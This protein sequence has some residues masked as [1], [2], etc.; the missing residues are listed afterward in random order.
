MSAGLGGVIKLQGEDAYRQA[1]KKISS[2]L[3]D[4]NAQMK[5][6]NST[7]DKNDKSISGLS[8]KND[9]LTKKL[10]AQND[11]LSEA[12]KMLSQAETAYSDAGDE[13]KAMQKA[14]EDAQKELDQA[15]SSTGA[16]AGEISKLEE[17]VASAKENLD[18]ANQTYD[19]AKNTVS[20]WSAEVNKAQADVNNTSNAITK[21]AEEMAKAQKEAKDSKSAYRELT[22]T[23]DSQ[24]RQLNTLKQQY[25]NVVLEQGK[26][27]KEA[28]SLKSEIKDLN[29]EIQ[30]N[31]AKLEAAKKG[32]EEYNGSL[33]DSGDAAQ[34]AQDGFTVMKGALAD[35]ISNGIQKATD[36]LKDL[37]KQTFDAGANFETAMSN[38]GAISGATGDDLDALTEKAKE[39]GSKTKFSATESA[40][41]FSYMAMAGWKTQDMIDGIDGVMNLAAASGADLAE[42]SDIVTDALT[43]MGYSAK[44][45]GELADVMAAAASNSNTNVEL[46]GQT[47]QYAAPIVGALG[48]NMEDTATAIGLMA[49]S[50]IKGEKAGTA[51]RSILTRLS[52]PTKDTQDAMDALGLSLTDSEGNMKDLNTV[53]GD[54]RNAFSGLSETQQT[55]YAKSIAGQEAMSGLLAIVNASPEDYDKLSDAIENSSGSAQEMADTMNDNVSGSLTLLK[56]QIEGEMIT[57]FESSSDTIKQAI[58]DIGDALASIDWEAVADAVSNGISKAVEVFQWILDNKDLIVSAL[59][60]IVAGFVAFKTAAAVTQLIT[61]FKSFFD[62]I[63][64]GQGVMAALNTVMSANPIA[65]IVAAVAALVTAFITAYNTSE[66]FRDTVNG[67]VQAV[68]DF[69]GDAIDVIKEILQGLGDFFSNLGQDISDIWDSITGFFSD[70]GD[71]IGNIVSG[72]GDKVSEVWNGIKEKTSEAWNNVK[73]SISTTVGNI[74]DNVSEGW[75]NIKEAT[76]NAWSNIKS[77]VEENGGGIKGVLKTAVDGYGQVWKAGFDVINKATGG[78]LGDALKTVRDKVEAIKNAFKEKLEKARDIVS[79]VIEKIKGFFNFSWSLPKLKLPHVSIT[80]EFSLVPPKVPKFS[81]DWYDKAMDGGMILDAPTIFGFNS[82]G[83]PMAGGESGSELV[84]GSDSVRGLIAS[85]VED[86]MNRR[87]NTYSYDT[88]V[89]AFQ[90]AL[91]RMTIELDDEQA[92]KF[93]RRTVEKA[94]YNV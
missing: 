64:S 81:V 19:D 59:A 91:S 45:S 27:S 51:L 37:A 90:T 10:S 42:T 80:G 55:Q 57:V 93:V 40:D 86:G 44:D 63:K 16:T 84:I 15:K 38:V 46:M 17:N 35:L 20:Q 43:A 74:K 25:T 68:K 1:L 54:L 66:D 41:A 9:L 71:K 22:D 13:V 94:I 6:V 26:N 78:K 92:G 24:E 83:Q 32:V 72:I 76:G 60:G 53:M 7:M 18:K 8:Q 30:D 5:L 62:I 65:I 52:A 77:K 70:A 12:K 58:K 75:N 50:G 36:G 11:K 21:N 73:D 29:G 23:I 3:T 82:N 89:S 56:S 2:S 79:G 14:L 47:F 39:M 4:L 34:K 48:Y 61:G 31:K 67:A 28:K 87:Q 69:I 49:N 88:I 85:A 33:E